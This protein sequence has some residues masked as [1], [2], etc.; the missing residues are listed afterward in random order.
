MSARLPAQIVPG[1]RVT[2]HFRLGLTDG[3]EAISTFGEDPATV[4]VGDGSLSEGLEIAL[5]GLSA[6]DRQTLTL[7]CQQAFGERDPAKVQ[8]MPRDRFPEDM[9]LRKGLAIAFETEAGEETA[10]I[11]EDAGEERHVLVDF[12][13]PLAGQEVVFTVQILAVE[14]T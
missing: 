1:S 5:Y 12:N 10:G 13:H 6:G 2:L 9:E 3:S 7:T 14:A 8:Q 4:T 11:I